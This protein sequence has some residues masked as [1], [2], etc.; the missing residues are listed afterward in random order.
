MSTRT[1]PHVNGLNR[2]GLTDIAVPS[3]TM[4][5]KSSLS[6]RRLLRF[7][8][9]TQGCVLADGDVATTRCFAVTS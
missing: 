1:L 7:I 6:S 2:L 9:H 4:G 3:C 5:A 8:H